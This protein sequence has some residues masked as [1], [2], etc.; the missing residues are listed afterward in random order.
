[1]FGQDPRLPVD[2]LLG[3]VESP[4]GG[5]VH[6][7]VQEHQ[8]RL[9]VAFEGARERLQHAADR[10]T[11]T[12]DTHVK[13]MP[14]GEGQLVF[15]LDF[16]ARGPHKTR[17]RWSS[18][19]YRVLRA[20]REGGPVYTIVPVDDPTKVR[21]VH[22]N[23]LK[24]VVGVNPLDGAP[25]CNLVVEEPPAAD[26]PSYEDGLWVLEQ[27][28]PVRPSALPCN[29]STLNPLPPHK[30]LVSSDPDSP[31]GSS[32]TIP[33]VG[34][35]TLR[36]ASPDGCSGPSYVAPRRT[37]RSTAGNHNNVHHL[38]RPVG[39]VAVANPP[40]VVSNSVSAFFRPWC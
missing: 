7:W 9:R 30:G 8:A 20:P 31:G 23:M 16:S 5:T 37:T 38:P 4:V 14:L 19:R 34:A 28:P 33:P 17:D 22:R 26:E 15:L 29:R 11:Q 39:E 13:D 27:S 1:M 18:V 10:K 3:R 35:S 36:V 21:Q 24:A 6:E 32:P 2:F 12:H 40:P 25:P